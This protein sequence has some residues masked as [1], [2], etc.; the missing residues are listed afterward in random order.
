M[1]I[2]D[3]PMA[4]LVLAI[5]VVLGLMVVGFARIVAAAEPDTVYFNGKIVYEAN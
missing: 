5:A 2:I 3:T 4:K 1:N